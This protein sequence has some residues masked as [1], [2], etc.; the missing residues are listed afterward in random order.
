MSPERERPKT[1]Q[2]LFSAVAPRYDSINAALSLGRDRA[3]RRRAAELLMVPADAE[4][5]DVATGTGAL[6]IAIAERLGPRGRVLGCDVNAQMLAKARERVADAHTRARIELL[7]ADA[8]ALPFADNRFD[9]VTVGF[10]IDD[11]SDRSQCARELF[12]VLAPGGRVV[13][14]ELALPD[15]QL[16]RSVYRGYL[17]LLP[18][19]ARLLGRVEAPYGHLREEILS[20]RGRAAVPE[21]LREVGFTGH[22]RE[23]AAAGVVSLHAASKPR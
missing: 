17:G 13:I 3:W 6:A 9:G 14:L 2:A 4:V 16:V 20:Y 12:R 8:T 5:L 21:L 11:V 23:D 22:T 10:A 1:P 19:A 7:V 18:L 15:H